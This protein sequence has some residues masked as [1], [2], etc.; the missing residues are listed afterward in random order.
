MFH[1][2]SY[3]SSEVLNR[4]QEELVSWFN[5]RVGGDEI[6]TKEVSC[7]CG[8]DDDDVVGTYDRFRA[9]QRIVLCR[10][11]GLMRCN[12]RLTADSLE[13][14]YQSNF[15]RQL[16]TT[17]G[18]RVVD[19]S[20]YIARAKSRDDRRRRAFDGLDGERIRRIGEVGCAEGLNLYGFH[21]DGRQV[22]GCDPNP[23]MVA[24]GRKMGLDLEQG[25]TERL[26]DRAF[27]LV[28]LSHVV[29]HFP[30]PLGDVAR[31]KESLAGGG[32]LYIEV[33]DARAFC[34]GALQSAHLYYFTPRQLV[35]YMAKIGLRPV[36]EN[37]IHGVHFG[38]VFVPDDS[39]PAVDIGGEY[40]LIRKIILRYQR[41][42]GFKDM[43]RNLGLFRIVQAAYW[44]ARRP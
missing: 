29:E 40:D 32:A 25:F 36:S 11:C 42:E 33:P 24:M 7:L 15:Y 31:V 3:P 5:D 6:P 9:A 1:D 37:L 27:D 20:E 17:G 13:W 8:A 43:L 39:A 19:E 35:H 4:E 28:I 26:G 23:E 34:L 2:P 38:M 44:M 21:L 14:F 41:R 22:W 12:P 10:A 18:F 30:D 16:Y